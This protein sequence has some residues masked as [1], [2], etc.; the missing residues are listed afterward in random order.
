MAPTNGKSSK[1][2]RKTLFL[3]TDLFPSLL[4]WERI[5][6]EVSFFEKRIDFHFLGS[7][8]P[9]KRLTKMYEINRQPAMK[10]TIKKILNTISIV[11]N[12]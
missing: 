5:L 2:K 11:Y 8:S 1:T 9:Y 3:F 12:L 6:S 4:F 10:I 7:L